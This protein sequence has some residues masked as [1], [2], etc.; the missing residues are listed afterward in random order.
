MFVLEVMRDGKPRRV[1]VPDDE[2]LLTQREAAG[3][4]KVG[5]SYLRASDCP[6]VLLPP[7][8]G[9]RPLVRY[10]RSAV[11]AWAVAWEVSLE[12]AA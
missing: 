5:V 9:T 2:V 1:E 7:A 11:L 8:R 4:L 10:R 3:I 12:D 6:K